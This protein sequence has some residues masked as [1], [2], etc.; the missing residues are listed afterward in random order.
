MTFKDAQKLLSLI[1]VIVLSKNIFSQA[2]TLDNFETKNRWN[3]IKSD[4]VELKLSNENGLDGK[5]IR[6]DYDFLKGTGYGG[7]QKFFPIDLPENYEFTFYLKANSPPNNF[8]IKFIDSSGNNVWWVNKHNFDFPKDW[9]KIKIK[10][11]HISFAWGPTSDH[12]LKR[13][14]RIEF[15]V[16]SFVGGKGTIWLDD[17]KFKPLSPEKDSYP[18]PDISA[19]S[20]SEGKTPELIIDSLY[21]TYWESKGSR[22]QPVIIDFKTTREFGGLKIN[23]L[24]DHQ[25]SAFDISISDDKIKWEK[26]YSVKSNKSDVSFI[27][28]PETESR[29]LK[30]NLKKNKSKRKFG[31]AEINFLKI[32]NS[33]TKNDFFIYAS[34]NSPLGDFPRYFSEEASYWTEVGVNSDQKEALISED[35]MVEIEKGRFSIE[36]ML[37]VDDKYFTWTNVKSEQSLEQNYLPVPSV[38]WNCGDVNLETK[39]FTSGEANTNSVLYLK[40]TLTNNTSSNKNGDLYLLIRP[41][42]VNPYYQ[43]LN[44]LGGVGRITSIKEEMKKIYIDD[45]KIIY[46]VTPYTNT[47]AATF[48]EGNLVDL[49]KNDQLPASKFV[50]DKNNLANG[51]IEYKFDLKSGEQ[52]AIYLAV[53][54]YERF[55]Q[56]SKL[57]TEE[58]EKTLKVDMEY[59]VGKLN[60][61][62]FYLPHSADKIIN[63]YRSNLAYILINRDKDG[64]QPGSRS[65]ERSWIRDGSLTS[66]ALLKSGIVEEVK[67]FIDWY[68]AY[69]YENGKVPCVVDSRGPDP[70]PEN[71]SNGEFIY[72]I[73][74]YYNFTKDTSFLKSKNEHVK[75]AVDY[76]QS[77][78]EQRST[79]HFKEGND[80]VRAYYGL[81]TESISHEGYSAKPMHSYWDNFFT[82]K[83]LKDATEI[84]K[85]LDEKDS[86]KR[87]KSLRDN[88]KE[89]L[90]NSLHLAM[91]VRD[92][93]YIPGCVELGD[94]DPTSTT[95]AISPCNELS[96]LPKPQIYNTFNKY[97]EFFQNRKEGK[98]DWVNYT[99]YENRI[100]GS[101][102][103]LDEPERAHQLIDFF[104]NDQRPNNW[105]DWAEVVWKD[106]REPK[107]IGD[108]PHTWVGS[109]FLNSV[110]SMFVYENEYD[111]SLVVG[112]ALYRDWVDSSNGMS[113]EN[114]PTYYGELSYLVKKSENKYI[115]ELYGD[116]KL[117]SGGIVIKNFPVKESPKSIKVNNNYLQKFDKDNIKVLQFPASIEIS[118]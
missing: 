73:K 117:P 23:W 4:G 55:L 57:T 72:L 43:F 61:I 34:Q 100:I 71:D 106:Y 112:A 64:I 15:T 41:F 110:R 45:D 75:K 66:S 79:E 17:L 90:Y 54:F 31:I 111:S 38:K 36:P 5:A 13:I 42:Q 1:L 102:V 76:L 96:D 80:S 53:P 101:F 59:W 109:D 91:K 33:L 84:Q 60:H 65:Y 48:D 29:Y 67:K 105:N 93:D 104:L 115:L 51:V 16:S 40:Y 27:N 26:I 6:F 2:S 62:K 85:I 8:E 87:I 58:I 78:I 70:V 56:E 107:F 18:I 52:K 116:I 118:Y 113:V 46:P 50:F 25:A 9:K 32:K 37:R 44:L 24:R 86:Y 7:I 21:D 49:I 89:N 12:S 3:F 92:I 94:F 103:F 63:T 95:I 39:I 81:V 77:L 99:P 11:R 68:S 28:L 88:F 20:F 69:Q 114:L 19:S 98:I 82:M 108:M 22:T 74:E 30:I 14:D 83:G 35:G 10:K 47:F 97:F